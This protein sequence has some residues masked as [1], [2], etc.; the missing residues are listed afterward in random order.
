MA[1]MSVRLFHAHASFMLEA[2]NNFQVKD[3]HV[4]GIFLLVLMIEFQQGSAKNSLKCRSHFDVPTCSM[5][6]NERLD[7]S[8]CRC[9][10]YMYIT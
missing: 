2:C 7:T 9:G 10:S 5:H 4:D 8:L 6:A 3:E 1:V